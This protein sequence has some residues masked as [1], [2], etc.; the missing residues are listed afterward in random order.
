M[1]RLIFQETDFASLPNPPAGF[2]YIGFDGPNF[3]Q[4]DE[5]GN[6][7][8]TGGGSSSYSIVT[9]F[10]LLSL[11]TSENLVPGRFYE[12]SDFKTCYDQP[13]YDIYGNPTHSEDSYKVGSTHSII[14]MAISATALS[15]DAYQP[16][17]PKDSIKYDIS[18]TQS[19]HTGGTAYGRITERID[20]WNN[21]TDYDHR[22]VYFKRY[23]YYLYDINNPQAGTVSV[24]GGIVT[25]VDTVFTNFSEG[26][27]IALPY[28]SEE[29]FKI[30]TITSATAMSLTG[31]VWDVTANDI[32]YYSANYIMN[33]GSPKKTNVDSES[34]NIRTFDGVTAFNN[35]IGD[36]A[37]SYLQDG[38][39]NFVLSNNV[40]LDGSYYNNRFG[41]NC[42]NN[43]FDDDCSNNTIGNFFS[44]NITDDDFDQNQ[45][46]NYF[47]R[48][49]ITANFQRN[50]VG[51]D[52]NDNIITVGSFY[53][54]RINNQFDNNKISGQDFQ[55]NIIGNGFNN[56][57]INTLSDGFLKNIIGVGFN[58]N[59]IRG[60][61]ESNTLG[62]GGNANKFYSTTRDN[63]IGDYF[64]NNIIGDIA[65]FGEV[66]FYENHIGN[67]FEN[68]NIY[69]D[70]YE[71]KIFNDFVSNDIYNFFYRNEIGFNFNDNIVGDFENY[72]ANDFRQNSCK[73]NVKGNLF[74]GHTTGNEFGENFSYNDLGNNIHQNIIGC[75]SI[76]NTI[77]D[78]FEKNI[79]SSYFYD[80]NIGN[81]FFSNT[82][83][84]NFYSNTLA[85]N[86]A[87]NKIGN[88]FNN[89]NIQND[90]G[91]GGAQ[92]FG[93]I[94]GNYFN[95]NTVGEYFYNNF[96][97]DLFN[98]NEIGDYFRN[99]DVK[100]HNLN[101]YN[102]LTYYNTVT[103]I[104]W[105]SATASP[106]TLH[107]AVGATGG[108]GINSYFDVQV[109]S[110]VVS[111]VIISASGIGF[112]VNDTLT[113]AS[114]SFGGETDLTLTVLSVSGTPSVYED[115]S[116]NIFK[117]SN[118]LD[119]LSY[120][121]EN[122]VLT[123]ININQ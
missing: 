44:H 37:N 98:G 70:F 17:F 29:V 39:G 34:Y 111:Q 42:Y 105:S 78:N 50:S 72:G 91:Y 46:G 85:N 22:E 24:V 109:S 110:G 75:E 48:N 38:I 1:R 15:I 102:F 61:F 5:N 35:Y 21:R 26:D 121:D 74:F 14:V 100:I 112:S 122:D 103:S 28:F 79:I 18:F 25:G 30:D 56:N 51:E 94:I 20:E 90:F 68:N 55:N 113:I 52:F 7:N 80:N 31:S 13:D 93:N 57:I 62:N 87:F 49:I 47:Q 82:I 53:R 71:N 6:T 99:N 40:F 65:N 2:K 64:Y 114:A 89:N 96:I 101:E 106:D 69:R 118:G 45:I 81:D 27:V 88:Y 9:Y 3:S 107:L 123:I 84:D 76:Y 10:S 116:C 19:E 58:N 95:Q 97:Q 108:S 33:F 12:I 43:T 32:K 92:S 115:Y 60:E 41:N 117:N 54:N 104:T 119:R 86:F 59:E 8:N 77:G 4:K 120:Y 83:G 16:D 11:V 73:S 63:K 66:Q 23:D 36:H 67:G